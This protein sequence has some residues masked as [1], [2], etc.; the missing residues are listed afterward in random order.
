MVTRV[1]IIIIVIIMRIVVA[2]VIVQIVARMHFH[3]CPTSQTVTITAA[4][5]GTVNIIATEPL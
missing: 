1:V 4:A 3:C 2:T 5:A